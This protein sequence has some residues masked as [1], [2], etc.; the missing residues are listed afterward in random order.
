VATIRDGEVAIAVRRREYSDAEVRAELERGERL[1]GLA[2]DEGEHG[3]AL[4]PWLRQDD[5]CVA[6]C[7]R[8]TAHI[9]VRTSGEWVVDEAGLWTKVGHS[10]DVRRLLAS[11]PLLLATL[12]L[13]AAS[14]SAPY[15][16][17]CAGA[18]VWSALCAALVH[19]SSANQTSH[20]RG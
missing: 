19:A 7:T 1:G 20:S 18:R 4:S 14:L 2:A 5:E 16:R 12:P 15:R 17:V 13:V 8:C 6:V 9:Y 11:S 3:H 10:A